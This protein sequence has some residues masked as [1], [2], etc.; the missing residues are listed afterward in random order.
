VATLL[1][2][3]VAASGTDVTFRVLR[4]NRA[5][6]R[7]ALPVPLCLALVRARGGDCWAA[8]GGALEATAEG[9]RAIRKWFVGVEGDRPAIYGADGE[10]Y[11]SV[12][13][14]VETVLGYVPGGW[15]CGG[16]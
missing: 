15:R 14:A 13:A 10:P 16:K 4:R 2:Y 1:A 5:G 8:G 11:P 12:C 3:P 6:R 9:L 7:L